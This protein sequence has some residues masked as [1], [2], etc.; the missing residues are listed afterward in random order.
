MES[1][2]R[3]TSEGGEDLR[4]VYFQVLDSRFQ[5]GVHQPVSG[6]TIPSE[7][8]TDFFK[9]FSELLGPSACAALLFHLGRKVGKISSKK[10]ENALGKFTC[11]PMLKEVV[12]DEER[13]RGTIKLKIA[14]EV[15]LSVLYLL[16]HYLKGFL[17]G[18]VEDAKGSELRIIREKYH[19]SSRSLYLELTFSF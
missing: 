6:L 17:K 15:D 9:C 10:L 3:E 2:C 18:F 4:K 8:L 13:R 11:L 19:N 7:H 12:F 1:P 16:G 14:D 5:L